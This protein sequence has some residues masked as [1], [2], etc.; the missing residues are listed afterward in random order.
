MATIKNWTVGKLQEYIRQYSSADGWP[1]YIKSV[2]H[3]AGLTSSV[4][5]GNVIVGVEYTGSQSVIMGAADGTSITVAGDD[6]IIL[7]DE[8]DSSDTVKYVNISQ[9]PFLSAAIDGEDNQVAV[10]TGVNTIEGTDSLTFD[11]S[12][13]EVTGR[14]SGSSDVDIHGNTVIGGTLDVTGTITAPGIVSGSIAG[15]GSYVGVNT[16][17]E[18]VLTSATSSGGGSPGGSDTQVQYNNGG[19]FGGAASL[20]YNDSTGHVTVID[21]KKLYFGTDGD[22][23]IEYNEDEND[24]LVISGSNLGIEISGSIIAHHINSGSAAG[25]GSYV[26]LAT[27]NKLVLAPI[28]GSSSG[29]GS[30]SPGGSDTQF[31]YNDGGA[32]GGAASLTYNDSDGHVTVIDD[33]KLYFGTNRDAYIE[34]DEDASDKLVISGSGE[35]AQGGGISLSGSIFARNIASG[36][37]AGP[38]SWIGLDRNYK[39]VLME[40]DTIIKNVT[41]EGDVIAGTDCTNYFH[42][43]SSWTASCDSLVLDDKK[44]I[45]SHSGT[46]GEGKDANIF[47]DTSLVGRH[48][49][50]VSSSREIGINVL[51]GDR[52]IYLAN[53]F[54][55]CVSALELYST[56]TLIF[57]VGDNDAEVLRL[58]GT[59]SPKSVV[60]PDDIK[61]CFGDDKD[62]TI[63]YDETTTNRMIIDA[64]NVALSG[65]IYVP[66]VATADPGSLY[67]YVCV[68]GAGK[69]VMTASERAIL[70]GS[71]IQ[72]RVAY[73]RHSEPTR[74][75]SSA[76]LRFDGTTLGVSTADINGGNIDDTTIGGT[77]PAAGTFTNVTVNGNLDTDADAISVFASLGANTASFGGSTSRMRVVNSLHVEG[78]LTGSDTL[79]IKESFS[80]ADEAFQVSKEGQVDIGGGFGSTGVT[81]ASNGITQI[82]G[83]LTSSAGVHLTGL[84]SRE[85]VATKYLAMDIND[86]V[87]LTSSSGGGHAGT[88]N[89]YIITKPIMLAGAILSGTT[90]G[91]QP[92]GR[93]YLG[94]VSTSADNKIHYFGT[95][96][97][98]TGANNYFSLGTLRNR[99]LGSYNGAN[100]MIA[101]RNLTLRNIFACG[102]VNTT[103]AAE[104]RVNLFKVTGSQNNESGSYYMGTTNPT[105][106][107]YASLNKQDGSLQTPI[108]SNVYLA[109]TGAYTTPPGGTNSISQ[110]EPILI[111]LSVHGQL[112][113]ALVSNL[114]YISVTAEFE[115]A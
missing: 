108:G 64:A 27:D 43:S 86:N 52:R 12:I 20:T 1:T 68:D 36:T 11:G 28:I 93:M 46:I 54:G 50:T 18:L 57:H 95:S 13:L 106:L 8:G 111:G 33:K 49:L 6:K 48:R 19:S 80:C 58:D 99:Q 61:L 85:A 71:G 84:S 53:Q 115:E 2:R 94:T 47:W 114:T 30:T 67:R 26:A 109:A 44:I 39:L 75:S 16:N 98:I 45:F 89:R 81:I 55:N 102:Q 22:A 51:G 34:Y 74:L 83:F 56:G 14:I 9:L 73:W 103:T 97:Y 29:G 82:S 63:Q 110:G 76:N 10:F 92:N 87:V 21:D 35:M 60:I 100:F 78:R 15:L 96:N 5:C 7:K 101:P 41:L 90:G 65:N 113:C 32:F 91:A 38:G 59:N 62:A 107:G 66:E 104:L 3:A 77:T 4:D 23:S 17:N 31:Q 105:K 24:R 42:F 25:P 112:N 69:L 40:P 37:L 72:N 88:I 70:T 79:E